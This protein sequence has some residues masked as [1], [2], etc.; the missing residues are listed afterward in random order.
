MSRRLP[1]PLLNPCAED[2]A[3]DEDFDEASVLE[4]DP[5][6]SF[7]EDGEPTDDMLIESSSFEEDFEESESFAELAAAAQVEDKST[8]VENGF[9]VFV[10]IP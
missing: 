5:D 1:I 8:A 7:S 10:E 6:Y 4:A 3:Y 9:N 2:V